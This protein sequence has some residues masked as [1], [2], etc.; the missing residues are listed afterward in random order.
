VGGLAGDADAQRD[1]GPAVALGTKPVNGGLDGALEFAFKP[2]NWAN[3]STS[4]AAMR[5]A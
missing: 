1:V 3:S 2:S 5:R 4:P